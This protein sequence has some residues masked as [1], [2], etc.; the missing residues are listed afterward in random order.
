MNTQKFS[1]LMI[2]SLLAALSAQAMDMHNYALPEGSV[3]KRLGSVNK[4]LSDPY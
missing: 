2:F 4:F 3:R 1:I